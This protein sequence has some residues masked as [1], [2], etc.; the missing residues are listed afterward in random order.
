MLNATIKGFASR[1]GSKEHNQLLSENRLDH[2]RETICST[3]PLSFSEQVAFG[4][5]QS[6]NGDSYKDRRVDIYITAIDRKGK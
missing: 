6:E 2:I 4:D 1:V 3:L 5:T